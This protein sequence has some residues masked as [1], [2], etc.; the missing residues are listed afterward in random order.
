MIPDATDGRDSE[1]MLLPEL[2]ID[3]IDIR[4]PNL[5]PKL[6]SRSCTVPRECSEPAAGNVDDETDDSLLPISSGFRVDVMQD[7]FLT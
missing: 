5:P 7:A 1:L 6:R 3:S 4:F 2:S